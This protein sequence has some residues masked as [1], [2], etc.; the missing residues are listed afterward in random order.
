MYSQSASPG[1]E[2][3]YKLRERRALLGSEPYQRLFL[4]GNLVT[5]S[6]ALVYLS[7]G[8][9]RPA[10][11]VFEAVLGGDLP[12]PIHTKPDSEAGLPKAF[13]GRVNVTTLLC[14]GTD[15]DYLCPLNPTGFNRV[16]PLTRGSL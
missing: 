6:T 2:S 14:E 1:T 8:P 12:E 13:A 15:S 5:T 4:S 9:H 3:L 10:S 11:A 7:G 16:G